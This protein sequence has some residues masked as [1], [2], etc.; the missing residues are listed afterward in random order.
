V[1]TG[2]GTRLTTGSVLGAGSNIYGGA[3]PPKYVPPFSWGEGDA[4]SMYRLDKFLSTTARVM[5]R[6]GVT[7]TEREKG[8]LSAA[9]AL[10]L[11]ART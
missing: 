2:I 7:L 9:H 8:Q 6:R 10:S 3:M 4:P 11:E 1:K 5:S